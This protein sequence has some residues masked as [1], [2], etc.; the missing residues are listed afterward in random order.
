MGASGG[1]SRAPNES[2]LIHTD[3]VPR[4]YNFKSHFLAAGIAVRH[5]APPKT[6]Y[7]YYLRGFF[8]IYIDSGG[9]LILHNII[10][11]LNTTISTVSQHLF[12]PLRYYLRPKTGV[13]S[14]YFV[15]GIFMCTINNEQ[16]KNRSNYRARINV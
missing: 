9:L 5:R 11:V 16:V 12:K 4:A 3:R 10:A 8:S 6:L 2:S 13:Q 7:K 15:V 14:S 1:P